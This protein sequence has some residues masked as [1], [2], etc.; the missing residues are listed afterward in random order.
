[1]SLLLVDNHKGVRKSIRDLLSDRSD[2]NVCCEAGNGIDA[3]EQARLPR[4]DI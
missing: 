2:W 4:P 3:I 1:L